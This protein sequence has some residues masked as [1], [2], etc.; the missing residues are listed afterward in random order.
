MQG[1]GRNLVSSSLAGLLK[2]I[3]VF[4]LA[5]RGHKQRPEY[6]PSI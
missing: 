5:E 3:I 6:N 1:L 4:S 2:G